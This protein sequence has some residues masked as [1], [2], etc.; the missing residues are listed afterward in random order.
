MGSFGQVWGKS[1]VWGWSGG[2]LLETGEAI[3]DEKQSEDG[4]GGG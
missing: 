3:W 1:G 4:P 2:I